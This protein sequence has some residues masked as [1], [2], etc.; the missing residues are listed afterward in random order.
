MWMAVGLAVVG[1]ARAGGPSLSIKSSGARVL[2][3]HQLTLSGRLVS[4]PTSRPIAVYALPLGLGGMQKLTTVAT[5]LDGRWAVHVRPVIATSYEARAG[6][7][8]T[9]IISVGVEPALV[10]R[11]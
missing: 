8:V 3:G 6:S 10:V 5:G 2:Y 1:S 9:Q 7:V 4:G 11:V